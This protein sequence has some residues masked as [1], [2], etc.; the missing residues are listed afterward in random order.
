M[1]VKITGHTRLLGFFGSP[2]EHSSSPAMHNEAFAQLGLDC[3]YL[4]FDIDNTRI[5][6]AITAFKT[7]NM[8]GAN[9]SMPCKTSVMQYLD[10]IDPA[11]K[12]C[13]AVNTIVVQPDGSLKGYSTD[14]V[15]YM[16]SLS[17]RGIDIIGKK[18]TLVGC[19]GAGKAIAVQAAMDGV[20]EISIFNA[21]D[22]FWSRCEES[23][24]DIEANTNCR[25][26]LFELNTEDAACMQ[27]LK[28]EIASSAVLANATSMGMGALAGRTYIP[29]A[30]YLRPDLVVTDT[31]YSP[32]KTALLELAEQV[33]CTT[34]NG[35]GMLFFQ[36]VA[37][38]KLWMEEDMPI[39]H[40]KKYIGL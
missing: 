39:E 7:F 13:G 4:A 12:L 15:G 3:V 23:V 14:G 37:A 8:R 26:N 18:M 5:E 35:L 25:V 19:G 33:G 27:V 36:G 40:M 29:D 32:A 31:I 20:R 6:N 22:A 11:A 30:S 1:A 2:A 17:D 21:R 16:T 38:F 34:V 9:V 10:E 28:D 24:R